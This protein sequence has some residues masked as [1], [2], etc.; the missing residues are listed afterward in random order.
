MQSKAQVAA[1]RK[2]PEPNFVIKNKIGQISRSL[3]GDVRKKEDRSSGN[4]VSKERFRSPTWR[5]HG[6]ST[7]RAACL[8][9][10]F[11]KQHANAI[12]RVGAGPAKEQ[13][14]PRGQNPPDRGMRTHRGVGLPEGIR[15]GAQAGCRTGGVLQI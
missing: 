11:T 10:T 3:R 8:S 2:S 15:H 14:R 7:T 9:T 4:Q 13:E 12:V 1:F 6:R 5:R